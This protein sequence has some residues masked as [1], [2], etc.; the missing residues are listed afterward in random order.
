M[1]CVFSEFDE[2][3]IRLAAAK[4]VLRLSRKWDLHISPQ[5]FR[6]T[7]LMAKVG[8]TL[9]N[10]KM[11]CNNILLGGCSLQSQCIFN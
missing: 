1:H 9:K 10:M 6:L 4:S 7:V 8:K 3:Q 11:D 2:A 5:I